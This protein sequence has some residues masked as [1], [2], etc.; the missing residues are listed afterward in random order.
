MGYWKRFGIRYAGH[1]KRFTRDQMIGILLAVLVVAYQIH[2]GLVEKARTKGAYLSIALPYV[3]VFGVLLGW[4]FISTCYELDAEQTERIGEAERKTKEAEARNTRPKI[5]PE[6]L[7]C[8]W[9]ID[10]PSRDTFS[11]VY[12]CIRLT[13]HAD[14]ATLITRYELNIE[15]SNKKFISDSE[16]TFSAEKRAQYEAFPGR[17]PPT[18]NWHLSPLQITPLTKGIHQDVWLKF[19][20]DLQSVYTGE[21]AFPASVSV[22]VTDSFGLQYSSLTRH[23]D[24]RMDTFVVPRDA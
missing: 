19:P 20:V 1:F 22:I 11:F 24:V 6:I 4:W 17:T 2:Y 8:F 10:A 5:V 12:A 13:N 7:E 23:A 21:E 9:D 18:K 14:V 16:A 15:I 3:V